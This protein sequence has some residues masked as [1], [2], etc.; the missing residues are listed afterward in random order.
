MVGRM[1]GRCQKLAKLP[2]KKAGRDRHHHLRALAQSKSTLFA[3]MMRTAFASTL[4]RV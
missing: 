1:V 2:R 4:M 3:V